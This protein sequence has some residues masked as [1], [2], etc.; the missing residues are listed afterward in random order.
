MGDKPDPSKKGAPSQQLLEIAEIRDGV[1]VLKDGSMQAV[2]MVSSLNFALKSEDEQNAIV[3][4][5]QDFINSLGFPVQ[6]IV[7]SRKTD[8]TPYL[9]QVRRRRERQKNELLRLQMD[10][11]INFVS[12]LVKNSNIMSKTFLV[13]IPF[14]V[15][16]SKKEGF[17]SRLLK[18]VKSVGGKGKMTDEEFG[19]NK[20]QLFQRAEQVAVGLRGIGLRMV[21]LQSQELI[22]LFYNWY[23]PV[24]SRNQ[25]LKNV[26]ELDIEENRQHQVA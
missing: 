13:V 14:T 22:E 15:Q 7:S 23:N 2:L 16:Q 17:F 1:V 24:T 11:Y 5:Y 4:A 25:R 12:E 18:G 9:E 6:I 20:A 10:E 3:Y 19:H 26:G 21:P 8:I